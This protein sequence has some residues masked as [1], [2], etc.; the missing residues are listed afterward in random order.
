MLRFHT[1]YKVGKSFLPVLNPAGKY[2]SPGHPED[3]PLQ[4]PQ[5][6]FDRPDLTS[7]GRPNLTSWGRPEMTSIG[8]L[9]LTFKGRPWEVDS[10][11][12]QDV[13][14]TSPRGPSVYSNSDI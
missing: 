13:L 3:V 14:R 1:S 6:L 7:R 12:P 11:R 4:R 5:I 10:G 8:R 9:N 2:W